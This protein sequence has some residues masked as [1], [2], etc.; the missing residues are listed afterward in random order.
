MS[1]IGVSAVV[2]S[3][4]L[5]LVL[6]KYS[7]TLKL[8]P[9]GIGHTEVPPNVQSAGAAAAP[10]GSG[11]REHDESIQEFRFVLNCLE[12]E[13]F[14]SESRDRYAAEANLNALENASSLALDRAQA[15]LNFY[16]LHKEECLSGKSSDPYEAAIRAVEN[17]DP[18][19]AECLLSGHL[20]EP[21]DEKSIEELSVTFPEASRRA[22]ELGVKNGD[23]SII[24][25]A[26]TA[27]L[28]QHGIVHDIGMGLGTEDKYLYLALAGLGA[29]YP[30]VI[31]LYNNKMSELAIFIKDDK[32]H[33]LEGRARQ[34]FEKSFNGRIRSNADRHSCQPVW[35]SL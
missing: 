28:A 31:A 20:P 19:A 21:M 8:S 27:L 13:R 30:G 2:V 7:S 10:V 11:H 16:E 17:G 22:V 29:D 33:E 4:L 35:S 5:V 34:I 18:Y 25:A 6:G 24:S 9:S 23:W 14:E 1:I 15:R 12:V 26:G 3:V 32:R